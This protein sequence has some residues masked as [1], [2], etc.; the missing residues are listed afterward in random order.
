MRQLVALLCLLVLA[1][2]C[3]GGDTLPAG[4]SPVPSPAHPSAPP[5]Q[6]STAPQLISVGEEVKGTLT[7]HCS[8]KLFELT[9]PSDGTLVAHLSWDPQQGPLVL[10]LATT[11]FA[12]A[13]AWPVP[14]DW[15][16]IVGKL[17][18]AVGQSYRVRVA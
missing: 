5:P 9:A 18:V 13:W 3:A 7:L 8:E 10:Q 2:A 11:E 17:P 16:P 14:R 12:G 15:S 4:P 1:S 6:S